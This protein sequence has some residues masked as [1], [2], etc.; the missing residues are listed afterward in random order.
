[1]A[2]IGEVSIV[3]S[4]NVEKM[5]R[6]LNE[7][8][9]RME[10]MQHEGRRLSAAM[11][12]TGDK[13]AR[14]FGRA[15]TAIIAAGAAVATWLASRALNDAARQVDEIGKAAGRLGTSVE[16]MSILRFAAAQSGVEFQR[17][18]KMAADAGRRVAEFVERGQTH[19]QLGRFNVQLVNASGEVR[20]ITELLPDLAKGIGS[21]GSAAQRLNLANKFFGERGGAQFVQL[22]AEMGE[23]LESLT[24]HAER[25]RRLGVVFTQ[26]TFERLRA[27][28]DA[29]D[30]IKEAWLGLRVAI[31]EK[32]APVLTQI[33]D[34][35]AFGL[36]AI[37]KVLGRVI[38]VLKQAKDDPQVRK[39]LESLGQRLVEVF[40][41]VGIGAGTVF[42]TAIRDAILGG[43]PLLATVAGHLAE[44]MVT[45]FHETLAGLAE[46]LAT[47]L[48][49]SPMPAWRGLGIQLD[50]FARVTRFAAEGERAFSVQRDREFVEK[51]SQNLPRFQATA[52][53]FDL[54][55]FNIAGKMRL[56]SE[57][58]DALF[59]L[60][61]LFS[62]AARDIASM[63]KELEDAN[64]TPDPTLWEQF[65]DGVQQGIRS[66]AEEVENL[67]V[68]GKSMTE[69]FV[70]GVAGGLA[71]ALASG[72]ASFR[73]FGKVAMEVLNNVLRRVAEM[74]LEFAL[75]RAM[76]G[77][78][79]AAS[80]GGGGS[81]PTTFVD[82]SSGG[83]VMGDAPTH[84]VTLAR[85][86]RS[87]GPQGG[88]GPFRPATAAVGGPTVQIIDQRR[89][90]SRPEVSERT[91]PDGR[92]VLSVL[93]RDEM[94]R[95]VGSGALDRTLAATF[96][97]R[98]QGSSR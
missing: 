31:A 10:S 16:D 80:G 73:N 56:F 30:R 9:R 69:T 94:E 29:V 54:A 27:Y 76:T 34:R 5:T 86:L 21:A 43:A 59:R 18:A 88:S 48:M 11:E 95:A 1:M 28:R 52:Q 15:R 62:E 68:L 8:T 78:F 41:A 60:S 46:R 83:M 92:R 50:E 98:R 44:S 14:G 90:G 77:I 96:G 19:A 36:A 45:S 63:A 6:A 25:A 39:A 49:S 71:K 70:R 64:P 32:I 91:G 81:T 42:V 79:G 65:R 93:I 58:A 82:S 35:V 67:D 26:E 55:M 75:M 7:T 22:I 37:P 72:E 12:S 17:L 38:E 23:G 85:M 40:E 47:R 87:L 51:L 3:L 74:A 4:A 13:I 89:S 97:L 2:S 84:D 33:A 20:A 57:E 66:I 24:V 61:D 53:A